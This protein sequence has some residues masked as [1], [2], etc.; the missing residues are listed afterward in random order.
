MRTSFDK[1]KTAIDK[2]DPNNLTELATAL[3]E[4]LA[5]LQDLNN[6]QNPT[7]DLKTN[8]ALEAAAAKAPNCQKISNA[9]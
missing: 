5:P 2:V 1:A 6:I 8:P 9:G 3:P 4:A 7:A